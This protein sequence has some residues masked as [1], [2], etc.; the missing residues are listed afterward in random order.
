MMCQYP[1]SITEDF[2]QILTPQ[3]PKHEKSN[4]VKLFLVPL[5]FGGNPVYVFNNQLSGYLVKVGE[6]RC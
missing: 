4:I 5:C 2:Q 1:K 3:T 6:Q